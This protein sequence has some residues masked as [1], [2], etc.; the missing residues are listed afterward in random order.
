MHLFSIA[1]IITIM[2]LSFCQFSNEVIGVLSPKNK[3][4]QFLKLVCMS[5]LKYICNACTIVIVFFSCTFV[6]TKVFSW[7]A[8]YVR[9]I[10]TN[11]I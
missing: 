7:D 5:N 8:A 10:H 2:R 9:S 1:A 4:S 6:I 3:G 11:H